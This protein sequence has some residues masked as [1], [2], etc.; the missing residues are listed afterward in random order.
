MRRIETE[1]EKIVGVLQDVIERP[2]WTRARLE[3]RGFPK[4]RL[5]ALDCVT[6]HK[7]GSHSV[8]VLRP[9]S[10][11][12]CRRIKLAD[13]EDYREIC[14]RPQMTRRDRKRLNKYVC[15]GRELTG[16][17]QDQSARL[18]AQPVQL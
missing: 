12:I 6:K 8:F 4:R 2:K 10:N 18:D 3:K 5:N 14:R 11:P 13:L 9:A 16:R 15:S 17:Q 7:G 1:E